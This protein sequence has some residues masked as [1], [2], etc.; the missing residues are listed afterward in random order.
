MVY[1]G[2]H[3]MTMF[4]SVSFTSVRP[5]SNKNS[6]I[7]NSHTRPTSNHDPGTTVG[8]NPSPHSPLTPCGLKPNLTSVML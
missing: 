5:T 6:S 7:I 4:I 3:T 1:L 2:F 8:L